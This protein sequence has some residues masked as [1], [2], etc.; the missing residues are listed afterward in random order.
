MAADEDEMDFEDL[1]ENVPP[2]EEEDAN[3]PHKS[4]HR[5]KTSRLW[6][7]KRS[8]Q[9]SRWDPSYDPRPRTRQIL[10]IA[11][12]DEAY[13]S[14]LEAAIASIHDPAR[15]WVDR[16]RYRNLANSMLCN[17][18]RNPALL[19]LYDPETLPTRNILDLSVGTPLHDYYLRLHDKDLTKYAREMGTE[20]MPDS[21][22]HQCKKCKSRKVSYYSMQTRSADE[23]MTNYFTCHNC[24]KVW[25]A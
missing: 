17:T 10:A 8:C 9:R 14:R 1:P 16:F 24:F 6:P 4:R 18:R 7:L 3:T 21:A 5:P 12:P 13:V 20:S 2:D 22:M 25:K 11:I 23:P 15:S 19:T